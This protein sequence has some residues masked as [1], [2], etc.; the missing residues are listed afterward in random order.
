MIKAQISETY[1]TNALTILE[2]GFNVFI[3]GRA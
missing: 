3:L 2:S 1:I